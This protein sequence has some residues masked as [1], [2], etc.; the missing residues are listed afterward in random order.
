MYFC[1]AGVL[2]AAPVHSGWYRAQIVSL[3]PAND[4]CDVKFVDY[5][6]YMTLP[7]SLLRQIRADFINLPFQA[8]ECYLANVKPIGGKNL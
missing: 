3:D 4:I 6:G 2:C 5:G 7:I 1:L 8:A